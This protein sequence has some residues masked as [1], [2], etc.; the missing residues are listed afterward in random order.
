MQKSIM[1][2]R[3]RISWL[4]FLPCSLDCRWGL[5]V[6][7][8]LGEV[9]WAWL[10]EGRGGGGALGGGVGGALGGGPGGGATSLAQRS[11]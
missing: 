7:A 8:W 2:Q 6:W 11:L 4:V 5:G 9:G 10:G 3:G 1:T